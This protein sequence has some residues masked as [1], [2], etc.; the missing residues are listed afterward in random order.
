MEIHRLFALL[1]P[2]GAGVS[3]SCP[4]NLDLLRQ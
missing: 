4:S 2:G 3:R 1:V